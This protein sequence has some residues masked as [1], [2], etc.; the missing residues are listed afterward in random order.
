MPPSSHIISATLQRWFAEN[1]RDLPWRET[2]NPYLIWISEIILQQTRVAQGY[3][4]YLRFVA[5]FPDVKTLAEAD[6]G[7]VLRLWQGLGYYSRARNL[8]VAAKQIVGDFDGR[9]PENFP[10]VLRLKG[11]GRYTAAA[12]CSFAFGTPVAVVDG[13][14]YRVLARLF[15][16][17]TP[18]D[19]GE[20]QKRFE[21]LAAAILDRRHPSAHNQAIME[22]GALQCTPLA[23]DCAACVLHAHCRA[24]ADGTVALL[25]VKAKKTKISERFFTYLVITCGE[26]IFIRRRTERDIWRGLYDF[27]LIETPALLTK[28]EIVENE[29]VKEILSGVKNAVFRNFSKVYKHVLTHRRLFAQFV[30]VEISDISQHLE[31]QFIKTEKSALADYPLPRLIERYLISD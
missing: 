19:S 10:D 23:P 21:A 16:E 18:I 9:F 29:A 12:I 20:G 26:Q 5:R 24:A 7:D 15:G 1:K 28:E 17:E 25:P 11:V 13:N 31:Q 8:H 3:D 22:F 14:V 4:Y 30:A 27:P 6:E 2:Q